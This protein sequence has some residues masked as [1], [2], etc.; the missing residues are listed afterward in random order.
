MR[1]C[2]SFVKIM[3]FQKERKPQ[4]LDSAII[5]ASNKSDNMETPNIPCEI[6]MK[7]SL[8]TDSDDKNCRGTGLTS[9]NGAI[10]LEITPISGN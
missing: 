10:P 8:D 1:C 5:P 9:F 7:N 2:I 3:N 4:N 6:Q